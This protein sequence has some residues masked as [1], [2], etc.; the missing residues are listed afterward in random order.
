MDVFLLLKSWEDPKS[1]ACHDFN[2]LLHLLDH[3]F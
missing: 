1:R 3:C 2:T